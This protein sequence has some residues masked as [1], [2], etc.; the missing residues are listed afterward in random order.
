MEAEEGRVTLERFYGWEVVRQ[1]S[2]QVCLFPEP[3]VLTTALSRGLS[4]TQSFFSKK[5]LINQVCATGKRE[6]REG[7]IIG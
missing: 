6:R 5:I 1:D 7:V 3:L 4:R 2:D